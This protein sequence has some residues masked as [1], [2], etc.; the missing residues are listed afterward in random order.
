MNTSESLYDQSLNEQK[1]LTRARFF[2]RFI[3]RTIDL[4]IVMA[5]Y[6]I[7]PKIGYFAGLFYLCIADGLFQGRSV[8]KRLMGLKVIIHG[9]TDIIAACSFKESILRNLPF[10]VGYILFGILNAIPFI[11]WIFAFVIFVVI[12]LFES[13][14]IIGSEKDMRLGDE[15]AKTQVVEEK[16]GGLDVS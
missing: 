14:V 9:N 8:G 12:L 15:I 13:L 4:I 11:G 10:A 7:I 5:L 2:Y 3:A 6:V 16:Q 1:E